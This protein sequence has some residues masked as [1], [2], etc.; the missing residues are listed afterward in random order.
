VAELKSL[1]RNRLL[2]EIPSGV[3]LRLQ[4]HL[5]LVSLRPRRI[6]HHARLPI[7]QA[8]F[9]ESGLVSVIAPTD[10]ESHGV[11]G[12]LIGYE[13]LVGT[14]VILGVSSS[15]HRRTVQVEGTAW[16]ITATDLTRIVDESVELRRVLLRYIHTTLVQTAQVGACN[17]RHPL[18]QRLAR[19]LLMAHDRIEEADLPLTQEVIAKMLGVRRASVTVAVDDLQQ[20]G[21]VC[22]GRGYITILDRAKLESLCCHCYGILKT[23]S[24]HEAEPLPRVPGRDLRVIRRNGIE[25]HL[26]PG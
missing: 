17:A 26:R 18:N 21:A 19:W 10:Q 8:Y 15:P 23:Q 5:R 4:P 7:E 24:P 16:A 25:E 20:T 11:E 3:F 9:I 6:L 14:P 2:R 22:A 1:P 13:G 12:W